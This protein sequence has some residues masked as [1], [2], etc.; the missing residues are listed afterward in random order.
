MI[1]HSHKEGSNLLCDFYVKLLRCF[2]TL[3]K[4]QQEVEKEEQSVLVVDYIHQSYEFWP[5]RLGSSVEESAPA[6][7]FNTDLESDKKERVR[8]LWGPS[9][10]PWYWWDVHLLFVNRS[11]WDWGID[12]IPGMR[13]INVF[14]HGL[15]S[16]MASDEKYRPTLFNQALAPSPEYVFPS[17]SQESQERCVEVSLNTF[18]IVSPSH[19]LVS[20]NFVK[21]MPHP[22]DVVA[23]MWIHPGGE[24]RYCCM[25]FTMS[26]IGHSYRFA[27]QEEDHKEEDL[28]EASVSTP[29]ILHRMGCTDDWRMLRSNPQ[30]PT[31]GRVWLQTPFSAASPPPSGGFIEAYYLRPDSGEVWLP[32]DTP[33]SAEE[34]CPLGWKIMAKTEPVALDPPEE[35]FAALCD[36][37]YSS[38]SPG[39]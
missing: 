11:G 8:W 35:A 18:K 9:A 34:L 32:L 4:R 36:E 23:L 1:E 38:Y 17:P 29:S 37:W 12:V 2:H 7:F 20:W 10:G 25:A 21:G 30:S 6:R 13:Y 19:I 24:R 31:N 14:G 28:E 39:A 5:C 15:L 26:L 3:C 27:G 16:L 22:K 33:V